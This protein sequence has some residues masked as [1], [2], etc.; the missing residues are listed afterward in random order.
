MK[1]G[2][3]PLVKQVEKGFCSKVV[4]CKSLVDWVSQAFDDFH[5]RFEIEKMESKGIL[6]RLLVQVSTV[7][8]IPNGNISIDLCG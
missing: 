4:P 1:S 3:F 5:H 6:L 7:D 2:A 8:A